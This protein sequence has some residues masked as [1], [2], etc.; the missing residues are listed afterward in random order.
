MPELP[1]PVTKLTAAAIEL[2][3]LFLAYLD[4]GFSEHQAF[5]LTRTIL[6]AQLNRDT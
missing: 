3:E 5:E 6:A 4:A 2:H 1:D